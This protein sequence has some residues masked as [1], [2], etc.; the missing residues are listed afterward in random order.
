VT[1]EIEPISPIAALFALG[2]MIFVGHNDGTMRQW[3]QSDVIKTW[4]P[5]RQAV[6]GIWATPKRV[7][8]TSADGSAAVLARESGSVSMLVEASRRPLRCIIEHAGLVAVA[9]GMNVHVHKKDGTHKAQLKQH[10]ADVHAFIADRDLLFSGAGDRRV[11]LWSLSK[12]CALLVIVTG[13]SNRVKCMAL[14]GSLLYTGSGD[15]TVRVFDLKEAFIQRAEWH[16]ER[17]KSAGKSIVSIFRG[18]K[19]SDPAR[20]VNG[21][22]KPNATVTTLKVTK[23]DMD[24]LASWM[25]MSAQQAEVDK[26]KEDQWKAQNRGGNGSGRAASTASTSS[27]PAPAPTPGGMPPQPVPRSAGFAGGSIAGAP[28]GYP[29]SAPPTAGFGM[30]S[31]GVP[32]RGGPIGPGGPGGPGAQ[33]RRVTSS[34]P[35]PF[36][37]GPGGGGGGG[38]YPQPVQ[39]PYQQQQ[40]APYAQGQGYGGPGYS[41]GGGQAFGQQQQQLPPYGGADPSSFR[42]MGESTVYEEPAE[43]EY[44]DD[45]SNPYANLPNIP[46]QMQPQQ[47]GY[48]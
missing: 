33:Q 28:G 26:Q 4:R 13:H 9:A 3:Q 24:D 39:Y 21:E 45:V 14:N 41:G 10:T 17:K 5:H 23:S 38:G 22:P 20:P 48:M 1:S 30:A 29:S 42:G 6:G 44:H 25:A 37:P 31:P 40:A 18:K 47:R 15:K 7:Y 19:P 36:A 34:S 16:K 11:V 2:D 46:Q 27:A 35:T 32:P 12:L 43:E 8:S